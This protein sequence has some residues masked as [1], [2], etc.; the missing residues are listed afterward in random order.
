MNTALKKLTP[1]LL[2]LLGLFV[3][4]LMGNVIVAG[5]CLLFGIVMV[6]ERIWPEKW[7]AD[8]NK[9]QELL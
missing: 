6:I 9:K 7:E 1:F 2:I 5:V 3:L 4:M 8:K